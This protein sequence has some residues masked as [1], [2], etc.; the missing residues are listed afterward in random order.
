MD[1][2][3]ENESIQEEKTDKF[4]AFNRLNKL[5]MLIKKDSY[6]KELCKIYTNNILL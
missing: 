5:Q 4:N 2:K 1:I 6:L 3:E